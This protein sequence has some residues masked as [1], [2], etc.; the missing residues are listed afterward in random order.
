MTQA[1]LLSVIV[2]VRNGERFL[3]EALDSVLAQSRKPDELVIVVDPGS[4]DRSLEIARACSMATVVEQQG[5]G[6][7]AA[8]NQGIS[9]ARGE[10]LA[11]LSADDRWTPDK[12]ERQLSVLQAQ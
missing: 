10:L 8:W 4:T 12:L 9:Q 5:S 11:F 1:P 3:T 2:P 7:A 6:I